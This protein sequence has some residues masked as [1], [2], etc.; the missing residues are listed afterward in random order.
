MQAVKFL[1]SH[2]KVIPQPEIVLKRNRLINAN[3]AK[4]LGIQTNQNGFTA[5]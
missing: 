3:K 4:E 5:I 1:N 2:K